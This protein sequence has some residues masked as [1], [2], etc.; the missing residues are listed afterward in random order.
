MLPLLLLLLSL[1]QPA[2]TAAATAATAAA[3]SEGPLLKV[4]VG[5]DEDPTTA[6]NKTSDDYYDDSYNDQTN[7]DSQWLYE[8][9]EERDECDPNP[10]YNNGVC[11]ND[12]DGDFKCICPRP[13]KGKR[14]QSVI[15]VC[16]NVRCGRGVCVFIDTEPF[17]ECKCIAPFQPPNCRRPSPCNPSPCL[18]G[19][20]CV[21][22]RTRASFHC[23][24]TE[25][26]S[27]KFC[28]VGPDD[29]Y[30]GDGAS[31]RGFVSETIS[32]H[33]C[34]PWN[35][36]F[37]SN[38]GDDDYT[39]AGKEEEEE[40]EEDD[41]IGPHNYC[42]N[43]DGESQ[44]WCFFRHNN[45]FYWDECNVRRCQGGTALT[46]TE[47]STE[48]AITRP[49]PENEFSVCGK[50]WPSRIT[51]RIFG[52][53]K[54]KPG[55][56]PWQV[57]LQTRIRNSTQPFTHDCGGTLLSS[58]WVLTAAHCIHEENEMQVEL[59]GV[60]LEKSEPADQK[61][62]VQSYILHENYTEI[63]DVQYN[64][65]ALLKLK[66]VTEDGLCARE[67]RYVK[68]A[69]LPPGPFP[70]GM[71]CSISGFGVTEKD[72]RGSKQLLDTK[73]LLINQNRCMAPNVLGDLLDDS[74]VCAGRMQG[75]VDACQGDSGGPLICKQNET[76]YI[77][78]VVSWG[79]GCGKKN[80]PG[81]Y[82]R[83]TK[84]LDWINEKMRSK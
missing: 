68:S 40:E 82:A 6:T 65:I 64:D 71:E 29:C 33:D 21:K 46:P 36:H 23:N 43:P 70:D 10:C 48:V 16:R 66:P 41:G 20:T 22:G 76:H 34:V 72:E 57:S 32:G 24:C 67:T 39:E 12:G 77:Y 45:T 37:V 62:A 8:L 78:G 69:C 19:G 5:I 38:L 49:T 47:P 84:F 9:I 79:D 75:G 18:N 73:V 14:C 63:D 74:M 30:E 61:L 52:G 80:K 7:T 31:Y 17:Y 59:G 13:F 28:Q 51:P 26:Y 53:R 3:Q 42:R 25:N 4:K 1:N 11:E 83:V 50:L 58:C 55:T 60:D 56:H 81:V 2:A 44:P 27:G 15:N 54:A 35:T